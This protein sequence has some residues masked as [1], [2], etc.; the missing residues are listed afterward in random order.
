[1]NLLPDVIT[2]SAAISACEK[3]EQWLQTLGLLTES[4]PTMVLPDCEGKAQGPSN[5]VQSARWLRRRGRGELNILGRK[6]ENPSPPNSPPRPPKSFRSKS[7]SEG[8]IKSSNPGSASG[9]K[10]QM[11]SRR[12]CTSTEHSSCTYPTD[13]SC[14]VHA[15]QGTQHA[16]NCSYS[17]T[18]AIVQMIHDKP[19][20]FNLFTCV[21]I[22]AKQSL[23][24]LLLRTY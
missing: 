7:Q 5:A 21:R 10:S 13:D 16:T 22:T 15:A 18:H 8:D 9:G 17:A 11:R 1:M 24:V 12:K 2:Y 19:K 3:S 14:F 20:Q 6:G 4:P 23:M